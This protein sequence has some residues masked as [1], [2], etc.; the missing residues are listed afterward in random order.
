MGKV[1]VRQRLDRGASF[2]R[3]NLGAFS[4]TLFLAFPSGASSTILTQQH[5]ET[6]RVQRDALISSAKLNGWTLGSYGNQLPYQLHGHSA[7]CMALGVSLGLQTHTSNLNDALIRT[8]DQGLR[9]KD[10]AEQ[11]WI[12]LWVHIF[13]GF[14]GSDVTDENREAMWDLSCAG[15][16]VTTA[17]EHSIQIPDDAR[18]ATGLRSGFAEY[19]ET[20]NTI[21]IL[22]HITEGYAGRIEAALASFPQAQSIGLGSGGGNVGEAVRAGQL[23]REAELKT[24]LIARCESACPLVFLGGVERTMWAPPSEVGFHMLS[25][26]MINPLPEGHEGYDLVRDFVYSMGADGESYVSWM[27]RARPETFFFPTVE[28]LCEAN[29]VTWA[30]RACTGVEVMP[31]NQQHSEF[32]DSS[33]K[34]CWLASPNAH[35]TN[36]NE[37]VNLRL[38]PD[39][40]ARVIRQVLLG[41]QVRPLRFDDLS[42][43]GQ[44][45]DRQSCINACQAFGANSEDR[46]SRDRVQQC[47]DDNMLWYEI[48]D[49]RGNRGWVSRKF[50]EE[51][52]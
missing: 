43:I 34:F 47:I 36:V 51:V 19:D 1:R 38:Q 23:I 6:L 41:E 4:A 24:E 30:Q 40:T 31:P 33:L 25:P 15:Q 18:I 11:G 14:L 45:R 10:P 8:V 48:T 27:L 17:F 35:V 3:L 26:D 9:S 21:N 16:T 44:E 5:L 29:I 12:A 42:V 50:L 32:V 13:F 39:F 2:L 28:Q 20:R 49:A 46:T 52:E 7:E 37:Y 22:G